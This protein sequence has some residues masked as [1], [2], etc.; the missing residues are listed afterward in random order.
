MPPFEGDVSGDMTL[1]RSM[2]SSSMRAAMSSVM[3]SPEPTSTS[4]GLIGL[5]TSSLEKRPLD[6]V[7]GWLGH[8]TARAAKLAHLLLV[9]TGPR[10]QHDVDRIH[11]V[12]A[13]V[14][15]QLGEDLLRDLVRGAGPDVD[16]LV[17]ALA[18]GDDALV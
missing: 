6:G 3:I 11:L 13:V 7:A 10:V 8:Q 14:V 5:I 18:V 15:F 9:T 1:T 4:L 16:D 12:L 2:P 17:V